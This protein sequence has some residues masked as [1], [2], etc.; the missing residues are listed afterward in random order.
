MTILHTDINLLISN[1]FVIV[2][3]FDFSKAFD[4]VRHSRLLK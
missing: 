2:I 4:T 1:Q 3:A